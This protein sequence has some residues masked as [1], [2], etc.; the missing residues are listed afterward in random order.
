MVIWIPRWSCYVLDG[1]IQLQVFKTKFG[2][3]AK[4]DFGFNNTM[5]LIF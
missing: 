4:S 3:L 2:A 1:F 5:K